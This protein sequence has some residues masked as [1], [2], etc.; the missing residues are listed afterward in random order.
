MK[1]SNPPVCTQDA[2]LNLQHAVFR[3][4]PMLTY[5]SRIDLKSPLKSQRRAKNIEVT[6][7]NH[8][9]DLEAAHEREH[10]RNQD[11]REEVVQG[12]QRAFYRG[13]VIRYGDVVQ[14]QHVT[15]GLFITAHKHPADLDPNSRKLALKKGSAAAHFMIRRTQMTRSEGAPIYRN[16]SVVFENV[17][18]SQFLNINSRGFFDIVKKEQ[19]RQEQ[20][21]RFGASKQPVPTLLRT[22]PLFEANVSTNRTKFHIKLH[23][24]PTGKQD[25][26]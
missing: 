20:L 21:K 25:R 3:L 16:D 17:Y 14:L 6:E 22:G 13:R 9:L 8:S 24:H 15:S 19:K 18:L 26:M 11:Q 2:P 4:V 10:T 23:F 12:K 5:N 7:N 1:V